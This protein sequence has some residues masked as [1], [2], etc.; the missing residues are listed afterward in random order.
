[1]EQT[2]GLGF[3]DKICSNYSTN[4]DADSSEQLLTK[5][6]KMVRSMRSLLARERTL[7]ITPRGKSKS[8]RPSSGGGS[9]SLPKQHHS[10]LQLLSQ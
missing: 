4:G 7:S 3:L 2:I 8:W 10:N 1:M 9:D 5:A 6:Q